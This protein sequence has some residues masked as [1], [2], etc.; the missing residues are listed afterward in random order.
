MWIDLRQYFIDK[1]EFNFNDNSP[2][3]FIKK[4]VECFSEETVEDFVDNF[5]YGE[6]YDDICNKEILSYH[7][8]G[9]CLGKS[10]I[11]AILLTF[12]DSDDFSEYGY[13]VPLENLYDC[14]NEEFMSITDEEYLYIPHTVK[15]EVEKLY[16]QA[17]EECYMDGTYDEYLAETLYFRMNCVRFK[18]K[19]KARKLRK[20]IHSSSTVR[21]LFSN[22]GFELENGQLLQLEYACIECDGFYAYYIDDFAV[23]SDAI[24]I[25]RKEFGR[26]D[27]N[28]S[29]ELTELLMT[30][31][32]NLHDMIV[33]LL[34]SHDTREEVII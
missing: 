21:H 2:E 12:L 30:G 8:F 5:N 19:S 7:V 9:D 31:S 22:A 25:L 34:Q 4:V 20:L 10:L 33:E 6:L 24:D 32:G 17:T 14:H 27:C 13:D 23:M 29:D 18:N 11:E 16:R 3:Y 28:P 26:T 1:S 15:K